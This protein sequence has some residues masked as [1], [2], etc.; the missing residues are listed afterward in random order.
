MRLSVVAVCLSLCLIGFSS[1][2]DAQASIR[3]ETNIPA[4]GLG[5]ALKALAKD[6]NFQVVYVTEE[7]AN[8]RTEGA[9]GEFTTEEALKRLLTGTGLTF[10]YLDDKTVTIGSATTP[11]GRGGQTSSVTSSQSSADSNAN[12]EGKNSSSEQFRL[13]Q[14]GQGEA[15]GAAAV[16]KPSRGTADAQPD[17]SDA[18][19]AEVVVTANKRAESILNVAGSVSVISAAQLDQ[20]S[21]VKLSDYAAFVPGL[22]VMPS[23]SPGLQMIVL[24]G[25]PPLTGASTAATYIDDVPVGSASSYENGGD[26]AIDIDPAELQRVEVLQ[27]PQG[28][29]YGGSALGGVVKYVTRQPD[30]QQ[31]WGHVSAEGF[32]IDG[33][34][35]GEEFRASGSVPLIEDQLA[36]SLSGHYRK[37]PGYI[38]EVGNFA[39]KNFN[40]GETEGGRLSVLYA[41]A[42]DWTINLGVLLNRISSNADNTV[43]INPFTREPLYGRYTTSHVTPT[44]SHTDLN[45][46]TVT[47]NHTFQAGPTFT[48]ATS[49]SNQSTLSSADASYSFLHAFLGLLPNQGVN[50]P[51]QDPVKRWTQEL[52]LASANNTHFE[53]L[54]GGFFQDEHATDL[55]PYN[56]TNPDGSIL[57]LPAPFNPI[58]TVYQIDSVREYAGFA[59]ASYYFRPDFWVSAGYRYSATETADAESLQGFFNS[60]PDPTAIQTQ[61]Y[62][63]S[64]DKGTYLASISWKPT[65]ATLLYARATSGYRPGGV[66]TQPP[67]APADFPTSYQSDTLWNYETGVKGRWLDGRITAAVD[68]FWIDWSNI[69]QYIIV[70]TFGVTGNGGKARSRGVEASVTAEPVQGLNLTAD[71][72]STHA[73]F[74]EGNP[75]LSIMAGQPLPYT[76]RWT[77]GVTANYQIP[78]SA[79]WRGFVGGDFQ[80]KSASYT[81]DRFKEDGYALFGL[82]VGARTPEWT[83]MAYVKNLANQYRIV[84]AN[85]P[86]TQIPFEALVTEPRTF[87]MSVSRS[88]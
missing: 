51:I 62:R 13:A 36:I 27:G 21:S 64:A 86:A 66:R 6:R 56:A 19:L 63:S 31:A 81:I 84:S 42:A 61:A 78:I 71:L 69:Q 48:S 70:N 79:N 11:A 23:Q 20:L 53:W 8:V 74:L 67:G 3:K 10:R 25:I 77:G 37:N 75:A 83:V 34:G 87:G 12:Q 29:L 22:Q 44:D 26:V 60:P 46:Y 50:A 80:Y 35:I 32:S 45:L 40:H 33:G 82:H 47:I 72:T 59:N 76:A 4:E 68:G 73:T 28:T 7:I 43:L 57:V 85:S 9:V 5:S 17:S 39:G 41:P 58:Y 1:A 65:D 2:N 18:Q 14:V 16:N 88:F 30:L 55:E 52:R 49:Y 24:R 54:V 38:D 15:A